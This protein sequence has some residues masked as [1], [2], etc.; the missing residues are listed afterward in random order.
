MTG[1]LCRSAGIGISDL[2]EDI[3]GFKQDMGIPSTILNADK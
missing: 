1:Q 2:D 3:F